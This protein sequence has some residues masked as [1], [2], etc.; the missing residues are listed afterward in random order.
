LGGETKKNIVGARALHDAADVVLLTATAIGAAGAL[1]RRVEIVE[2][3]AVVALAGV[4]IH[5]TAYGFNLF[6]IE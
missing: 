1:S 2:I 3:G 4:Y 5:A 6:G